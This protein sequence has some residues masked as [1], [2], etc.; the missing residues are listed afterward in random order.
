MH[1]KH[2]AVRAIVALAGMAAALFVT[3]LASPAAQA[4][5]AGEDQERSLSLI[6]NGNLLARE[7]ATA[8]TCNGNTAYQ[9]DI[10]NFE[11][12]WT[13]VAL[14]KD[15]ANWSYFY[16]PSTWGDSIHYQHS[17][18]NSHTALVLCVTKG[19][20]WTCGNNTQSVNSVGG[21]DMTKFVYN[22]GF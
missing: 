4:Y 2:K 10:Y 17:D 12:G 21:P 13:V 16:G 18:N 9:G 1:L 6:V 8:N 19:S 22:D 3:Q 5:C 15:G 7:V 11:D 20:N 14:V